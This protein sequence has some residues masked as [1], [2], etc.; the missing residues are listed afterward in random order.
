MGEQGTKDR[1]YSLVFRRHLDPHLVTI[2]LPNLPMHH[3]FQE[4]ALI[5]GYLGSNIFTRL[6]Y[7]PE[8]LGMDSG[9]YKA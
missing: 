5:N 1:G 7:H 9:L 8:A 4:A 3:S 2:Y 6:P